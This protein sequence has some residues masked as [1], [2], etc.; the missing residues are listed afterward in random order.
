VTAQMTFDDIPPHP[1][2]RRTDPSTSHEAAE[3]AVAADV[4][5]RPLIMDILDWDALTDDEICRR[6]PIAIRRWP[7]AKSTRSRLKKAGLVV[8]AGY[9]RNGQRVWRRKDRPHLARAEQVH[10]HGGV[11]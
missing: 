6:L 3:R 1:R 7:S 5:L 2:A 9:E 8:F 10:V 4:N 11:L